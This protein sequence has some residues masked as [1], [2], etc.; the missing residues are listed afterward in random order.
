MTKPNFLILGA[1]KCGTSWL[2]HKL[3][4]HPDIFL[5]DEE[6]HFFD[7]EFNF[8]KG[9]D[10]YEA[11]FSNVAD[12]TAIGEKTPDYLWANGDGAE[13][14]LADVHKNIHAYNP[15]LKFIVLMRDPVQRAV[16]A[17]NH[18]IRSGR[19]SPLVDIDELLVG[20]QQRLVDGH[21]IIEK[22]KYFEQIVA[23][24]KYF[25]RDQ[26]LFLIYEED[27]VA[28]PKEGLR[29]ACAFLE[30]DS[31][32]SFSNLDRRINAFGRSTPGLILS[33]YIPP[34]HWMAK[35][36]DRLLP[37]QKKRPREATLN[38]LY[39]LYQKEN[40]ALFRLLGRDIQVWSR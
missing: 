2:R 39:S 32:W 26:F 38:R 8:E 5:S 28:N 6:V 25:E 27:V 11:Q 34:F 3:S 36:L 33:W 16:S 37:N 14:H 7:K 29:N 20:R 24:L 13:G 31:N 15:D 12:E 1:Q 4:Q 23:Y 18:L 22:G 17:A 9:I 21:G 40:E 10:W 19:I 35:A 30:V